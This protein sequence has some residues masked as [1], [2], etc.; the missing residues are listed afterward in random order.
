[1]PCWA[2][3]ITGIGYA[4]DIS[5]LSP[6]VSALQ[7]ILCLCESVAS[8]YGILFNANKTVCIKLGRDKKIPARTVKLYNTDIPWAIQAKHLG[9]VINFDLS[10]DTDIMF[11]KSVF[12]SQVNSEC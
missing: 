3:V 10:D 12:V 9:N 4:D 6:S 8:D 5:I 11:K 7:K 2:F 1:M